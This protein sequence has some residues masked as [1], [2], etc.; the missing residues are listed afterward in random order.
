MNNDNCTNEFDLNYKQ[1]IGKYCGRILLNQTECLYSECG[2]SKKKTII[3]FNL[4]F[5]FRNVQE[6][7]SLRL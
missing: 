1:C 6:A 3:L 7:L 5:L 4:T 2:V